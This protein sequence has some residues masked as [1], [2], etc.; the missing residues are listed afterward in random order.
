VL[1]RTKIIEP[2]FKTKPR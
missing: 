2:R 1:K